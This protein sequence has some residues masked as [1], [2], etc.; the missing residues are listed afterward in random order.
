MDISKMFIAGVIS[1]AFSECLTFLYAW[2]KGRKEGKGIVETFI[3]NE[4]GSKFTD[5]GFFY[6]IITGM[7]FLV[8]ATIIEGIMGEGITLRSLLLD[9]GIAVCFGLIIL[10]W[11]KVKK[12][13]CKK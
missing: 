2:K 12:E 11:R 9:F 7:V 3:E 4:N 5:N 1:V 13:F 10:L 8:S 6:E